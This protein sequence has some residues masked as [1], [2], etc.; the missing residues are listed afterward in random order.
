M[1]L[2]Q[3]ARR[4]VLDVLF[5]PFPPCLYCGQEANEKSFAAGTAFVCQDCMSGFIRI[6]GPICSVCGRPWIQGEICRDCVRRTHQAFCQSR[7][8]VTYNEKA[9]EW[10]ARYKYRGDRVLA[11]VLAEL[12]YEVWQRE[13]A[14]LSIDVIAY[15]PLHEDRLMERTFNQAEELA[16]LLGE[17]VRIPVCGLLVRTRAT[18]KQSMKGRGDRLAALQH[19]FAPAAVARSF[20]RVLLVDDV[21][22]TGSSMQ[23]AAQVIRQQWSQAEVYGITWAR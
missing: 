8:A 1:T 21:Y 19:I 13:Y 6:E 16:R 20:R 23:A 10:L 17:R 12:L 7:S 11:P 5:P 22:T 4:F 18:E 3:T 9:K 14:S 2:W 15:M